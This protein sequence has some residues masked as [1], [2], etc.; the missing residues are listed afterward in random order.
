[1]ANVNYIK[2]MEMPPVI[3]YTDWYSNALIMLLARDIQTDTT[4]CDVGSVL[5]NARSRDTT[6][7]LPVHSRP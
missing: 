3:E 4:N 1:M 6:V 2:C 5:V 7:V